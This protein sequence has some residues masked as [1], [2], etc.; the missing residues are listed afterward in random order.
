VLDLRIR[1][2]LKDTKKK[3]TGG[4]NGKYDDIDFRVEL[5]FRNGAES[6]PVFIG[7]KNAGAVYD[8]KY[9]DGKG[10]AEVW[11]G[12][13]EDGRK[14][15]KYMKLYEDGDNPETVPHEFSHVLGLIDRYDE[16][17]QSPLPGY[18]NNLMGQSCC[19]NRLAPADVR[20]IIEKNK[21]GKV[22]GGFEI[23]KEY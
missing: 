5:S 8:G 12:N 1:I 17:T 10:R 2:S 22:I 9:E 13:F 3:L 16:R 18:E 19:G 4:I 11:W 15:I 7:R 23:E 14:V 21:E 20:E 6:L